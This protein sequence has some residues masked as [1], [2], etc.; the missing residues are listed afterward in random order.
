M[1]RTVSSIEIEGGINMKPTHILK[2][3]GAT[4]IYLVV[5]VGASFLYVA[6]YSYVINPG[7][8]AEFYQEYAQV[9]SPYSSIFA[10]MPIMFFMCWRL[11]RK[12]KPDFGRNSVL[13][14]WVTYVIIDLT[15][16]S[17][18]GMM[19][20]LAILSSISLFTKL[21]AALWGAKIGSAQQI[22]SDKLSMDIS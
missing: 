13:V 18:S 10:G 17:V 16:L 3:I 1:D 9:A 20:R 11:S 21:I 4:L 14:I 5:N 6:F 22:T 8:P 2:L 15:V 12:W 7:H 19:G